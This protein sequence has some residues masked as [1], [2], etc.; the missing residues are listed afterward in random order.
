MVMGAHVST[1]LTMQVDDNFDDELLRL[2]LSA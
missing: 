2:Y 1:R